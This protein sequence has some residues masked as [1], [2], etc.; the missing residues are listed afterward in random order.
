MTIWIL[1]FSLLW[2]ILAVAAYRLGIADGL[3]AG[4]RGRLAGGKP[5]QQDTLLARIESYSGRKEQ[6]GTA[7]LA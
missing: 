1:L 4:R 2:P 6:N 3:S 7:D 5:E